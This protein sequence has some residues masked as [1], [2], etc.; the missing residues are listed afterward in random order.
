MDR[1]LAV[2]L[3]AGVPT[4]AA[5]IAATSGTLPA[6]V[7]THFGARGAA[8]GWMPRDA[9][10][11]MMSGLALVLPLALWGGIAWTPR[12]WP[13]LVNLPMRDY[14]LAPPRR[15]ATLRVLSRFACAL[16]LLTAGFLLGLHFAIVQANAAVPARLPGPAF[17]LLMATFGAGI[18][19]L[20][21]ALSWRFRQRP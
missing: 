4:T 9:Y 21:I 6:D 16:A 5:V 1:V 19:A 18:V 11:A 3:L 12:R 2:L 7:A 14:W 20:V 17:A 10:V 8:N 13:G 15:E